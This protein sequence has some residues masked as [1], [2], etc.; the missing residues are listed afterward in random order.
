MTAEVAVMNRLAVALAADSAVTISRGDTSKVFPSDNKIFELS[1]TQPV[2]MMIYHSTQFFGVPWEI[3]AKDFRQN[4][5]DLQCDTLF[6]WVSKFRDFIVSRFCPSDA[7]QEEF[8]RSLIAETLE[9]VISR[10]AQRQFQIFSA[11]VRRGKN[12]T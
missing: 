10:F 12:K 9:E 7:A 4:H 1:Q 3:I 5:A 8:V 6:C 11:R 2:G